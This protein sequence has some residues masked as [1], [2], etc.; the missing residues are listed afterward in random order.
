[1]TTTIDVPSLA[2]EVVLDIRGRSRLL[3]GLWRT[4][5]T[6]LVWLRHFGCLFCKE[7]AAEMARVR[8]DIDT[9]GAR[10]A[11]VGHGGVDFARAFHDEYVPTC[12]VYTDPSAMTY[13]TIG[14]RQSAVGTIAGFGLHGLRAMARGHV[15]TRILGRAFQNGG[16]LIVTPADVA[17]YTYI[18][19]VA[20]DHPRAPR[21]LDALARVMAGEQVAAAYEPLP[22]A[23][24]D[25]ASEETPR[26]PWGSPVPPRQ[27]EWSAPQTDVPGPSAWPRRLEQP[28]PD[29]LQQA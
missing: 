6:V 11:F 29:A 2:A 3:G 18:S 21:V 5:P 4:Q 23:L 26:T 14:A 10:L 13:R 7:Q 22:A 25:G 15:Q 28:G 12:A 24:T 1:M 8:T 27:Y 16:V 17:A 20:G 19:R 9:L